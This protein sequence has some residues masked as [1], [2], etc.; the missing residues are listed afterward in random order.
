MVHTGAA[1]I[2]LVPERTFGRPLISTV[3]P[4]FNGSLARRR[5]FAALKGLQLREEVYGLDGS[6][7][8]D[9]PYSVQ[10]QT[11]DI[12]FLQEP[13][14]PKQAGVT[15]VTPRE[16]VSLL[17]ERER[18]NPRMEQTLVLERNEFGSV[19][20]SL[21]VLHGCAK[22]L[23]TNESKREIQESSVAV[24]TETAY[25]NL[26]TDDRSFPKPQIASTRAE[27][28]LNFRTTGLISFK[29][30]QNNPVEMLRNMNGVNRENP[31]RVV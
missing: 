17:Y 14:K 2:S 15:R 7:N 8:V 21:L 12:S 28:I 10:E 20:R 24:L 26:I 19:R 6:P 30:V 23:I 11:F 4:D 3:L 18:G 22:S 13:Q 5:A 31:V 1:E 27:H 9:V 29:D 16:T 25:T